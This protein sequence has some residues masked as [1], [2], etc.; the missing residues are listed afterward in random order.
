MKKAIVF[1]AGGF[2]G[3]HLVRRLKAEGYWVK[4]IDLHQPEYTKGDADYFVIG[5]LT[6]REVVAS[7]IDDDTDELYQLAADMGGAGYLFTGENDADVMHNSALINLHTAEIATLKKVKNVFFSSSACVY[8]KHN[9]KDPD[10]PNCSED[11]VYPADPDSEYGWEKLFA[12]RLYQ[13]FHRNHGLNCKIARFHNVYGPWNAWR[14]GREKAPAAICRKVI[15]SDKTGHIEIWGD[16][17]QS[18]SFL[19]IDDCIEGIR[20]LMQSSYNEPVNIGSSE[21]VTLNELAERTM[22][23]FNKNVPIKHTSGPV[24]VQGRTSDNRLMQSITG[25]TPSVSL[26]EGIRA[27]YTWIEEQVYSLLTVDQCIHT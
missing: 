3:S 9:Q 22:K 16:G 23:M 8:P 26:N 15:E 1:G 4:G 13:S 11:S 6:L 18:R 19:F 10:N 14:G 24:G 20:K 25:W 7:A 21:M 12:E 27:T 2:I 5:N 17:K